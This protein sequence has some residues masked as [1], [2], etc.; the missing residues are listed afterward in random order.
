MPAEQVVEKTVLNRLMDGLS[1]LYTNVDK[2]VGGVLPY[3][4]DVGAGYL[5][6]LYTGADKMAGGRLPNFA[7]G[8]GYVDGGGQVASKAAGSV[9]ADSIGSVMP[10]GTTSG[11]G[12]GGLDVSSM[13]IPGAPT[14]PTDGASSFVDPQLL[15]GTSFN[16]ASLSPYAP[17][18]GFQ[19]FLGKAKDAAALVGTIGTI[20]AMLD[21]GD[22]GGATSGSGSAGRGNALSTRGS[23]RPVGSGRSSAPAGMPAGGSVE[24]GAGGSIGVKSA[25]KEE[26]ASTP[27]V[28]PGASQGEKEVTES[29]VVEAPIVD[30]EQKSLSLLEKL[31]TAVNEAAKAVDVETIAQSPTPLASNQLDFL[32]SQSISPPQPLNR[33]FTFDSSIVPIA[34]AQSLGTSVGSP[35]VSSTTITPEMINAQ[36]RDFRLM[37]DTASPMQKALASQEQQLDAMLKQTPSGTAKFNEL[38]QAR[39]AI[40]LQREAM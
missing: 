16:P 33:E 15:D 11:A 24:P 21:G 4:Q 5:A 37:Y 34:N 12:Q 3:G 19:N 17:P 27:V 1:N 2:L 30:E 28:N 6:N 25:P 13:A 22:T 35:S 7:E 32:N 18:S 36:N 39:N 14:Y 31:D 8:F 10:G 29:P 23:R 38:L 9:G 20:G 40:R 26:V